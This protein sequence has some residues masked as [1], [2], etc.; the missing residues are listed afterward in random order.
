MEPVALVEIQGGFVRAKAG[1]GAIALGWAASPEEA[2]SEVL[3]SFRAVFPG[4]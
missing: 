2:P 3:Q 1:V 4:K